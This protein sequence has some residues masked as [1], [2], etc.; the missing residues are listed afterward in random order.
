[1]AVTGRQSWYTNLLACAV[2][3]PSCMLALTSANSRADS[4]SDKLFLSVMKRVTWFQ[5]PRP[6]FLVADAGPEA[7]LQGL[8]VGTHGAGGAADGLDLIDGVRVFL[9]VE[10]WRAARQVVIRSGQAEGLG[11]AGLHEGRR[12][13]RG[14]RRLPH[15]G[16]RRRREGLGRC[17]A[18]VRAPLEDLFA[19][20][21][22][23]WAPSCAR[24]G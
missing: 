12:R 16:Q 14:W 9:A 8:F 6:V 11:V 5:M 24:T 7:R 21:R 3:T 1:M 22:P 4:I 13:E 10:R 15:T 19:T 2:C 18:I 20:S 17:P 23:T